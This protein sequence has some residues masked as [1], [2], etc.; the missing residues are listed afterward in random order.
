M[1]DNVERRL[2]W[3]AGAVVAALLAVGAMA[4]PAQ[5]A[6]A[7]V[8]Q[9]APAVDTAGRHGF[10]LPPGSP[11]PG[12]GFKIKSAYKVVFGVQIYSCVTNP[13]GTSTW[14]TP[15]SVPEALLFSYGSLRLIYHFEGPRWRALD[16]STVVAAV[17][18]RVPKDGTIPWLLLNVTA[19]ENSRPGLEL[20]PVTHISRVN[21]SGGV[22][23]TGSCN[24]GQ[25]RRVR[26]GADYVFWVPA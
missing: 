21:T 14:S 4:V 17:A 22:G 9:T 11:T 1:V 19:H 25:S 23:P 13:D 8:A 12:P 7:Q 24:P 10:T 6:P 18:Q 5:A 15:A 20:D 16:G 2:R 26:Y 3:A